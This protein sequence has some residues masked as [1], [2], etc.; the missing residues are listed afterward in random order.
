MPG[1]TL[2]SI[3]H[4]VPAPPTAENLEWA[5][6][7][8]IDISQANTPEGRA[9]LAPKVRDAM[10]T[11]GFLYV[12]NHGYDQA[13]NERIFDIA[14]LPFAQVPE[15]EKRLFAGNIKQTGSYRGYKL[16]RYWHIEN[17]VHDQ[18]EHYNLHR[19]IT[20]DQKH[21][22]ALQPVLPEIRA[23]AEH[24]HFSVLHPLLRLLARGM[25][26][27]EDTFVNIHGFDTKGETYVRFMK[28]YPRSEEEE[29]KTKNVWLKG[30]TDFGTITILWS[31]PVSALQILSPDGKWK[32]IR[33]IPNALVV[34][35]GDA[36]EFLSGG[37]YKAT[38]HRVVQPP[39]DQRG[40]TRVGA[41]YFAM[42][43]DDVKLVPF[44][45]SP[46]FERVDIVRKCD[47]A[48]APTME[49][50]RKG[51]TSAYGQSELKRKDEVVEEEVIN[52]VVV[53]H[54]N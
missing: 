42:T 21:P 11:Q 36:M 47:D 31:Q 28:Y 24:N 37:F 43:D 14:D 2:P 35:A 45:E 48:D 53:K 52:G 30:H 46:V 22:K 23:F 54:Y 6:L 34:N 25:E 39:A 27:P 16:R 5:D 41:F 50:W 8:I 10:R 1:T 26:L 17:G 51:R 7:P 4:Y 29:S 20:G 12:V 38:I 3:P 15:D 9:E 18:L 19:A 33:H 49:Q 44:A 40:Y 13:K 32:W